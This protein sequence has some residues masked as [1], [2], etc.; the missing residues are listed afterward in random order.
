MKKPLIIIIGLIAVYCVYRYMS[1]ETSAAGGVLL[2]AGAGL[3]Q[4][5][6]HQEKIKR[7]DVHRRE[8]IDRE[9][10][11]SKTQARREAE[12]ETEKWLNSDF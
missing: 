5:K 7:Q 3:A 8:S 10:A 11:R 2:L 1:A 4:R 12:S 9:I 6:R